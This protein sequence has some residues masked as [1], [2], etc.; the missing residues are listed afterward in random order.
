MAIAGYNAEIDEVLAELKSE[1]KGITFFRGKENLWS[2]NRNWEFAKI[3]YGQPEIE[4]IRLM[5][6]GIY[7]FWKATG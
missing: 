4:L 5:S 2:H 6:T 1:F 7:H 3:T